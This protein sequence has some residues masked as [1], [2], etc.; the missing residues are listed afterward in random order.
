MTLV[1]VIDLEYDEW[2]VKVDVIDLSTDE[3]SVK[4]YGNFEE[5]DDDDNVPRSENLAEAATSSP[6]S[7]QGVAATASLSLVDHGSAM[8]SLMT[9]KS[10]QP[11]NQDFLATSDVSKE[12]TH[13]G[14][15]ELIA[16]DCVGKAM[17]SE[18]EA[19][20][21]SPMTEQA[22]ATSLLLTK[23]GAI[24]SSLKIDKS[25]LSGNQVFAAALDYAEDDGNV[26]QSE[27]LG[28]AA[29]S[30]PIS[31]QDTTA[32]ASQ[33]N[34][35]MNDKVCN[36][37]SN[38]CTIQGCTN[39]EH[40][41]T[42]L[43]IIHNSRPH[44]RC[45]AVIECTKVARKGSQGR[46]D[47]CIKHGG[48]K[49][50]KYDRCGKGAKG[51]TDYCIAHGGGRRCKFQGCKKHA[52]GPRDYCL[53]HGGGRRK[54]LGCSAGTCGEDLCSMHIT[55]L[56]SGNNSD[57]KMMPAPPAPACQAKMVEPS[58]RRNS[59]SVIG[60]GSQK[61]Q[62]TNDYVNTSVETGEQKANNSQ[63]ESES[64]LCSRISI[65]QLATTSPTAVYKS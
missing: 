47:R 12:A 21:F 49:R 62:N 53:E 14:N 42:H 16:G 13:S 2:Y 10:M 26:P 9:D 65:A 30:S 52:Q 35:T 31:E 1:D 37:G 17:Q 41:G 27:N 36:S 51:K 4:K 64:D 56:L 34:T 28:E 57:H 20:I 3:D 22:A 23:Q 58:K 48:G 54:Y 38:G 19:G 61:R 59:H 55:S 33:G 6:I 63:V 43:C 15:H 18:H 29:T 32:S 45:C 39:S 40:G 11:E 44:I 60:G 7:E 24:I 46:T 50:C 8:S 5:E 25:I